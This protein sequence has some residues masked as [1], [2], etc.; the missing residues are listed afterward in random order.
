VKRAEAELA[1]S[2]MNESSLRSA[3]FLKHLRDSLR[4]GHLRSVSGT[5]H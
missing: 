3:L 1:E 5:G 4:V 2:V